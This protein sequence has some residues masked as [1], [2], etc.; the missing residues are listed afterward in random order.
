ME[1]LIQKAILKAMAVHEGQTRKGDGK[2]PY[3]LHPL[4][5]GLI[6]ARYTTNEILI[7]SAILHDVIESGKVSEEELKEEFGE[8]IATLVKYLT[9]DRTI[10]DWTERKKEN[11]SRLANSL[12]AYIIRAADA[13]ANMRDLFLAVQS[14]GEGV[15]EKF[16]APKEAKMSYFE[17]IL[18][19]LK[20]DLPSDFIERYV[21]ALKDLQYSHLLA[22]QTSELGFKTE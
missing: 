7:S 8:E 6:I 3:I 18:D 17:R 9:E 19:D 21:S 22:R 12:A 5:V 14:Q 4:E 11:L 13:L 2:T 15:W 16:N 1:N 10:K 20:G